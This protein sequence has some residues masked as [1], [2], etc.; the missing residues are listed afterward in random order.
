MNVVIVDGSGRFREDL[1]AGTKVI[2]LANRGHGWK[3]DTV[4]RRVVRSDIVGFFDDDRYPLKPIAPYLTRFDDPQCAG[5]TLAPRNWWFWSLPDGSTMRP[6]GTYAVMLRRATLVQE[7]LW[8]NRRRMP[9]SGLTILRT[10]PHWAKQQDVDTGDAVN[11][12]ILETG[13]RV[14]DLGDEGVV[15]GFDGLTAPRLFLYRKGP[16]AMLRG[17]ATSDS[18]RVGS[19]AG[20]AVRGAYGNAKVDRLLD[21]LPGHQA[22]TTGLTETMI[23]EVIAGHANTEER[24]ELLA[25]FDRLDDEYSRLAAITKSG[26]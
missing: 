10:F 12:H 1:L 19:N 3:L 16:N 7:N 15:A 17:I 21:L 18:L 4:V 6:M 8:M 23:R 22:R 9:A 26:D 5:V 14:D 11:E 24:V 20:S 25:Y 13:R 2:R